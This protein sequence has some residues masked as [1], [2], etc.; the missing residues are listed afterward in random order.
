MA[1]KPVSPNHRITPRDRALAQAY[2]ETG[3]VTA[4]AQKVG[5]SREWASRLLNSGA[6]QGLILQSMARNHIDIDRIT[7]A[8]AEG[9]DAV[10]PVVLRGKD[11]DR[12]ELVDDYKVRVDTTKVIVEYLARSAEKVQPEPEP[13]EPIEVLTWE[14]YKSLTPQEQREYRMKAQRRA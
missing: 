11:G 14:Q 12:I 6:L 1:G 9:L 2:V 3:S 10:K 4:A 7:Q 5:I 13:E 8:W